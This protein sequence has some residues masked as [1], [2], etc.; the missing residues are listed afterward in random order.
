MTSALAA[1]P[2]LLAAQ[3]LATP[4]T[5]PLIE[6]GRDR[7]LPS[8]PDPAE[9]PRTPRGDLV[10]VDAGD[11]AVPIRGVDFVG[12]DAP[13]IVADAARPFLGRP[14][15]RETLEAMAKAISEAYGKTGIALYTVA[16]PQQDLSTGQVKVLLAEGFVEDIAY[17][18]GASPLVQAY[19]E[20]LRKERPLTRRTLERSLSLIRDIPGA[21]ADVA[22]QR[23][24]Q[25]GGVKFEIVPTRKRT[26]FSIGVN[27]LAQAGLGRGQAQ[28]SAQGYSLFRDGDRT[29]L[30]YLGAIDFR[31][32]KYAALSHQ[33]PLGSD[34]LTLGVSGSWLDTR[35]AQQRISGRAWTAGVSV[36]YPVIRGYKRNLSV[37]L[38][39]DGVNS[40]AALLSSILSSDRVR[41]VRA[42]AGYSLVGDK[43]VLTAGLTVSQGLDILGAR[44]T[45]GTAET[46]FAKIAGRAGY[47]RMIGK[48]VIV[49]LRASG[50]YSRDRLSANERFVIGG[51][52]LGRAFET[53]I[54]SG[55]RGYGGS[56][57]LALRPRLPEKLKGTEAYGFIDGA[58]LRILA[59]PGYLP[60]SFSLA[61]AGGG[62]R[63]AYNPHAWLELEGARVIEK[64]YATA[65]DGWRFNINW[66]LKLRS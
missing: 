19:A 46:G 65:P 59:R 24:T 6:Q 29:D 9:Q 23:G 7:D 25:A 13:V 2:L 33:T 41:A 48:M 62:M 16:I 61:S 4:M 60:G 26:D 64:P 51:P 45:A 3:S 52:D 37:S 53:A 28:A 35:I 43:S 30:L 42:G 44:T 12:V 36:S 14:A 57:E 55:D 31:Q 40:D 50:Q 21:K 49:R 17:P 1:W 66:R 22:L 5:P 27:N 10:A 58:R 39:V 34:G 8:L 54:I 20:K 63:F 47:D 56:F 18:K 15:S 32:F 11:N 38:G